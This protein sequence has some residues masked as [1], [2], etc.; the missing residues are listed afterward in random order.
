MELELEGQLRGLEG[1]RGPNG[2]SGGLSE[3]SGGPS[4]GSGSSKGGTEKHSLKNALC[5]TIGHWP[6][7]GP[8]PKNR[9]FQRSYVRAF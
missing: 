9:I 3:G 8:L 4:E 6:L 2:G 7:P 5:G 1:S